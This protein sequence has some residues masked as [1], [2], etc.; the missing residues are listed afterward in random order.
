MRNENLFLSVINNKKDIS[1]K[2]FPIPNHSI[3][4]FEKSAYFLPVN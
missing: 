3:S 4:K 2:L 1:R